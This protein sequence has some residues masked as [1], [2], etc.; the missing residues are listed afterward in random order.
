MFPDIELVRSVQQELDKVIEEGVANIVQLLKS[1]ES[2]V[3]TNTSKIDEDAFEARNRQ[4]VKTFFLFNA[5][6]EINQA[7]LSRPA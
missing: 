6:M 1:S 2:K 5:Q 4:K 7:C 3:S